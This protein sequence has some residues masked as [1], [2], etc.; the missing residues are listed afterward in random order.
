MKRSEVIQNINNKL[1]DIKPSEFSI[2][3]EQLKND[4]LE[5]EPDSFE[6]LIKCRNQE[7]DLDKIATFLLTKTLS[8]DTD[9]F[10][11]KFKYDPDELI[12][13]LNIDYNDSS[14]EDY[15]LE[16]VSELSTKLISYISEKWK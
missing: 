2:Y 15:A 11:L 9:K 14:E 5:M 3:L 10:I 7:E 1:S 16:Y 8:F 12:Q 6:D 13:L 4:L